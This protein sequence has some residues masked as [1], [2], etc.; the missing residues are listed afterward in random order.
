MNTPS[1][2]LSKACLV[3]SR[4]FLVVAFIAVIAGGLV[5]AVTAHDPQR[6]MMWLSAYLVL[7]VGVAQA[8]FGLG[9]ALLARVP[10]GAGFRWLQCALFNAGSA[11]VIASQLIPMHALVYPGTVL[12]G[13]STALF[14]VGTRHGRHPRWLW[15]YRGLLGFLALSSLV[16]IGLSWM[17]HH[18]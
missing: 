3:A 18:G 7:V 1:F 4:P 6:A 9:Q 10:P 13:V 16:G 11:L 15:A 2:I 12:F 14:L 8:A 5:S 17:L